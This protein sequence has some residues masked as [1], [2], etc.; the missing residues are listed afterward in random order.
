M[1]LKIEYITDKKGRQKSVIISRKQWENYEADFNR[2]KNK[3]RVL[4]G[5]NEALDEVNEIQNGRKKGK[6]L[7]QIIDEL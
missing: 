1:N 3:I 5:L 6:S 4:T 7:K 2:M